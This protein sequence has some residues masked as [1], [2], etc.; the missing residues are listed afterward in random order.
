[1]TLISTV[2]LVGLAIGPTVGGLVLAVAP[3]QVLLLVNV[4]ITALALV[5]IRSGI[6]ADKPA[7]LHRDRVDHSRRSAGDG[8]NRARAH[9]AHPVCQRGHRLLGA[10]DNTATAVI[11]AACRPARALGAVPAPR[12]E[13]GRPPPRLRRSGIQGRHRARRRR[14]G[15]PRDL[16]L[17]L[18]WGWSPRSR[19]HRHAAA[20]G[21][22]RRRRH[23]LRGLRR[24][25]PRSAPPWS[26]PPPK[27]LPA[28]ASWSPA[29]SSP[30]LFTNT[31]TAPRW[32]A[33][34]TAQF[35]HAATSQAWCS[36]PSPPPSSDGQSFACET[37]Q[38]QV[39]PHRAPTTST[40]REHE[41]GMSGPV[42]PG[43]AH[44]VGAGFVGG[45]S[46]SADPRQGLSGPVGGCVEGGES[47]GY[48][49]GSAW[50]GSVDDRDG[51]G[52]VVGQIVG[53]VEA[54]AG[55]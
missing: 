14:H 12:S 20:A 4:P 28:Q 55:A 2:G 27:S 17:R 50:C 49:E 24:T 29:P 35:Q 33:P 25:G 42:L 5:G 53:G 44:R 21:R 19:L 8:D 26:T 39:R 40:G 34:A 7:E 22:R 10:M 32:S 48:E 36:P 23:V 52:A 3:W 13:A 16:R 11:A 9:R 46:A 18:D 1:M 31:F 30:A 54:G 43:Q 15:L 51:V 6:A 41:S 37:P 45:G 38:T 47:V